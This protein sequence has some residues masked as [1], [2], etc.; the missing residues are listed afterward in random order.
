VQV[1]PVILEI[2]N[3][4][5]AEPA[6]APLAVGNSD[7]PPAET[8]VP[9]STAIGVQNAVQAYARG[10]AIRS[11]PQECLVTIS[12]ALHPGL[13]APLG[14]ALSEATRSELR[15]ALTRNHPGAAPGTPLDPV[16]K[17]RT[18]QG[19]LGA[20]NGRS[21]RACVPTPP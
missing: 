18:L 19:W 15:E 4:Y 11:R 6:P 8:F 16:Y 20:G 21:L 2:D 17:L 10:R 7:R 5:Q 3:H 9:P 14:W 12:P 1:A 13:T